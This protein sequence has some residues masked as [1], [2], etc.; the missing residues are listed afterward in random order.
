MLLSE[1]ALENRED[2]LRTIKVYLA[3][4]GAE[5]IVIYAPEYDASLN[6][7]LGSFAEDFTIEY[8]WYVQYLRLCQC[9]EGVSYR[10]SIRLRTLTREFS[11]VMDEQPITARVDASGVTVERSAMSGAI[12][13]SK[14]ETQTLLLT[15]HGRYSAVLAPAGDFLYPLFGTRW[16]RLKEHRHFYRSLLD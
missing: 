1:I 4:I 7:K 16:I 6:A 10:L 9:V 12:V 15:Q 13:L 14:E 5:R 8:I 2:I 3:H 11:A